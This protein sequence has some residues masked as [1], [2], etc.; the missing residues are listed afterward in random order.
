[1]GGFEVNPSHKYPWMVAFL[2]RQGKPFCSGSIISRH[3]ILTAAH[4][5]D[6]IST[7]YSLISSIKVALGV[8]RLNETGLKEEIESILIHP[9]YHKT[10]QALFNDLALVKLKQRLVFN[11][12]RRPICLPNRSMN[13]YRNLTVAGW[14]FTV[15]DGFPSQVLREVSLPFVENHVCADFHG[16]SITDDMICAGGQKDQDSCHGDSGSPLMHWQYGH[17]FVVGIVSYGLGCGRPSYYGVNTRVQSY[18]E[19]IYANTQDS[20]YCARPPRIVSAESS[21]SNNSSK[22][23]SQSMTTTST[24]RPTTIRTSTTTGASTSTEESGYF[25]FDK[26]I[27]VSM[28]YPLSLN[29]L[30]PFSTF[31]M[32]DQL[33]PLFPNLIY[34]GISNTPNSRIIGGQEVQPQAFPWMVSGLI[35]N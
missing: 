20:T 34:C 33:T 2:N 35:V 29:G 5:F 13:N 18:L 32:F 17:A 8:Q 23:S 31:N 28:A 11:I 22:E 30:I 3:Y 4:C 9:K 19:W 7:N 15:E 10:S 1:M 16:D 21:S 14:G 12:N 27:N 6:S 26:P 24:I 25:K